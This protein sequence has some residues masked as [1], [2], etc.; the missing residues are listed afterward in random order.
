MEAG[1]A[2]RRG[3][4]LASRASRP[5]GARLEPWFRLSA[6]VLEPPIA[7]WFN[8][9]F[10]GKEHVPR[11]GPLL[12]A[13]NHI[14]YLDPL[15]H[16]LFLWRLGRRPR[17]LAKAELFR[18]RGL[19]TALR[20][21]KQIPVERG[22][23]DPRPLAQAEEAL[24]EGE[25]V[26]V[27]PEGTVTDDPQHLPMQGKTGIV[28]LSLAT[29]IPVT[30]VAVWGAQHVWQKSGPGSLKFGRPIWL[31]A[32]AAIDLSRFAERSGDIEGLRE[33][34][35]AVMQE[36]RRLV[37]DLRGRYPKRWS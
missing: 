37:L 4:A 11:E 9:S 24:A 34:T 29:G 27:Y 33:A 19:G 13:A 22:T 1:G 25:A 32:G 21:M 14:S 31:K 23:G 36:L 28:R 35:D 15:A 5:K 26:V 17:Y 3:R 12:V 18:V 30:P 16:G 20:G 2:P 10:E 8:W 6:G 7:L